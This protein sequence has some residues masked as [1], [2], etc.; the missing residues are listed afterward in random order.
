MTEPVLP[1]PAL[2]GV[3]HLNAACA[4]LGVSSEALWVGYISVGGGATFTQI[5]RWLATTDPVPDREHDMMAQ[6]LNDWFIDTH[7]VHRV[8]YADGL[9]R[10]VGTTATD[11]PH[12]D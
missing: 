7:S 2:T 1:V 3:G 5:E 9:H 8:P 6:A 4:T 11:A 12:S 10:A